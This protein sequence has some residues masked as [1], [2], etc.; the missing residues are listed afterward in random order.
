MEPWE[1]EAWLEVCRALMSAPPCERDTGWHFS[2]FCAPL[3]GDVP[4]RCEHWRASVRELIFRISE[5]EPL[6]YEE[7]FRPLLE[8]SPEHWHYPLHTVMFRDSL[9]DIWGLEVVAPFANFS[10]D[11][12]STQV[13]R[14]ILARMEQTP[15]VFGAFSFIN[16]HDNYLATEG[17]ASLAA[18]QGLAGTTHLMLSGTVTGD[19]ALECLL[20]SPH[21]GDLRA[22]YLEDNRI[23]DE[24][25]AALAAFPG[26]SELEDLELAGNTITA[27]GWSAL[28]SSP[29]L[30]RELRA[31]F[32]D[33]M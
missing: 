25:A 26:A 33:L 9:A 28:A 1:I 22:L 15:H 18:N 20:S 19:E 31:R 11:A 12:S 14:R 10:L 23:T 17:I 6:V 3:R 5:A 30:S 32:A 21:I 7:S 8:A 16:L 13:S 4:S 24:G 29:Y 27:E 2:G